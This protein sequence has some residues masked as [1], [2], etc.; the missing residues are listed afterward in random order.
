MTTSEFEQAIKNKATRCCKK[1]KEIKSLSDFYAYPHK[2][3]DRMNFMTPCKICCKKIKKPTGR[4]SANNLKRRFGLTTTQYSEMLQKQNYSCAICRKTQDEFS[5]RLAVDHNHNTGKIGG[6]LCYS[7]NLGLSH[8]KDDES[9]LG[10]AIKY[11]ARAEFIELSH[12]F[13][14]HL[15]IFGKRKE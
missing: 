4:S 10:E 8:F 7:C 6:L 5:R 14:K 1:C 15:R 12:D 2:T 3:K 9:V 13:L 11:L